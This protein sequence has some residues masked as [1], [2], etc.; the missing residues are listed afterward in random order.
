MGTQNAIFGETD[1]AYIENK[2]NKAKMA[3]FLGCF[4]LEFNKNKE[5]W[6][7]SVSA[8]DSLMQSEV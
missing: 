6:T 1:K 5:V 3:Y 2:R 7:N 8:Q 4:S